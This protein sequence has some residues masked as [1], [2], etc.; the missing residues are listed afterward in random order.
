MQYQ[1][2]ATMFLS[3]AERY[4]NRVLYR[5]VQEGHWRSLTWSE[6]RTR[7]REI[8]LGLTSLGVSR[9]DRVAILSSN[10]V[11]WHLVDWANICIGALTVPIYAS[12]TSSPGAAHHRPL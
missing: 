6:A 7:V 10:R 12:S 4:G 11:E 2:L 3:Q 5:F 1:S 8:G 9:R